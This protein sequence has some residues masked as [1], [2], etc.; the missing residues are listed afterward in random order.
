MLF[1]CL[2]TLSYPVTLGLAAVHVEE[3][4][5]I[6]SEIM[7]YKLELGAKSLRGGAEG[8]CRALQ[9][10]CPAAGRVQRLRGELPAASSAP[11]QSAGALQR[12][13]PASPERGQW[14]SVLVSPVSFTMQLYVFALLSF[15]S[16]SLQ[17]GRRFLAPVSLCCFICSGDEKT[18]SILHSCFCHASFSPGLPLLSVRRAEEEMSTPRPGDR[19]SVRVLC[20]ALP[21]GRAAMSRLCSSRARGSPAAAE[22][23]WT[24]GVSGVVGAA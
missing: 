22:R 24:C 17:S 2:I 16:P 1:N 12:F 18:M 19:R 15:Q 3:N 13:S 4:F 14:L 7:G 21:V 23:D 9:P 10:S 5:K 20:L 8:I 11:R 6:L